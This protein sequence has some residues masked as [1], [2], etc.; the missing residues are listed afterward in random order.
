MSA[1]V[2][3]GVAVLGGLGAITRFAVDGIVGSRSAGSF[4]LGT[5]VVNISGAVA[6]GL[7]AGLAVT[8]D[9]LVLAGGAALGSYTT[10][11]TWMLES[12]RLTEDA[13]PALACLNILVSLAAGVA[14]AALG[15]AI[16]V[17]A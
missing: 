4:P 6:L 17:H 11:S 8:G 14:G 9:A 2:W 15:H 10:F 12:Q 5:L 7:L 16:G 1:W 3:V 13:E